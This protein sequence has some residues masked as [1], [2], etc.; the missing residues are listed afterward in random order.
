MPRLINTTPKYRK[1]AA[2]GQAIATLNGHDIYLGPYGRHV[3]TVE[4]DRLVAEWL[5]NGRH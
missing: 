1:H 4:Y 2:S 5:A 3:S